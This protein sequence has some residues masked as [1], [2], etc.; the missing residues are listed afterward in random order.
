M[1]IMRAGLKNYS[2]KFF[3]L[4]LINLQILIL[5]L[6]HQIFI[7]LLEGLELK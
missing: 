7:C 4:Y 5:N 2:Q 3:I 6:D 1:E